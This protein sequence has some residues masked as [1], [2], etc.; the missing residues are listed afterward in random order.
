[1]VASTLCTL[2]IGWRQQSLVEPSVLK[3][4]EPDLRAARQQAHTPGSSVLHADS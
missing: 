1:M 3:L 4:F 2:G